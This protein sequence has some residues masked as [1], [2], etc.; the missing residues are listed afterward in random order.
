MKRK[1]VTETQSDSEIQPCKVKI[2][3]RY[4]PE[5]TNP[6]LKGAPRLRLIRRTTLCTDVGKSKLEKG[7]AS[8]L[9]IFN[10]RPS[11]PKVVVW[12]G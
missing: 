9:T 12:P 11:D 2:L 10:I 6:T 1:A 3:K 7:Q 5:I 8:I 4:N